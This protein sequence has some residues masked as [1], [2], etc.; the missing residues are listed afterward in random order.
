MPSLVRMRL[1]EV[2]NSLFRRTVPKQQ[3]VDSQK[4]VPSKKSSQ[5]RLV[6]SPPARM[7]RTSSAP[8]RATSAI[9]AWH[10]AGWKGQSGPIPSRAHLLLP[11]SQFPFRLHYWLAGFNS[12]S[13]IGG[14]SLKILG[15]CPSLKGTK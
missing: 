5:G 2:L 3:A 11:F 6:R 13:R 10:Q 4:A 8:P 14:S 12:S 7:L 15:C 1:P 9:S